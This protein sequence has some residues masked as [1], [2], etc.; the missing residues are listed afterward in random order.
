[1]Y[2]QN[3]HS[4]AKGLKNILIKPDPELSFGYG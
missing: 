2:V 4:L 1:M 3:T